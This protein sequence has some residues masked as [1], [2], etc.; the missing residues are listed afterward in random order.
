MENERKSLPWMTK[1]EF[2]QII[3]LRTMHLSKGAVPFVDIPPDLKIKS[4]IELRK[5]AIE[6]LLAGNLPYTIERP[7][8]DKKSEIWH[9]KE[10]S[11]Q[12]IRHMI[13]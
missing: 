1:Y 4:N 12:A 6:E 9:V 8:P 11:L 10:L 13:R 3:G 2:N 5:I 7:M